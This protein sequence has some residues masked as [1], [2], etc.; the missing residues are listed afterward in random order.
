M[1][2]TLNFCLLDNHGN[3][4]G[5]G[6]MFL[7]KPGTDTLNICLCGLEQKK[8]TF[9]KKLPLPPASN[10]FQASFS[11][12]Y[13]DRPSSKFSPRSNSAKQQTSENA[14]KQSTGKVTAVAP[15]PCQWANVSPAINTSS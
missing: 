2:S 5:V 15:S 10:C 8:D 14:R 1:C 11:V 13:I 9:L 7:Y 3:P 12:S 6:I 4:W